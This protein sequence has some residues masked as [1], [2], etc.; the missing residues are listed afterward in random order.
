LSDRE[1]A[2]VGLTRAEVSSVF[3]ADFGANRGR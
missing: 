3:R 2:D 1:L